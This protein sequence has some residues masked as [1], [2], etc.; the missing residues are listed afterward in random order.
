MLFVTPLLPPEGGERAEA[1]SNACFKELKQFFDTTSF[2]AIRVTSLEQAISM[3]NLKKDIICVT[4]THDCYLE[5]PEYDTLVVWLRYKVGLLH[6]RVDVPY[7]KGREAILPG[8]IGQRIYRTIRNEFTGVAELYGGPE[9]MTIM[10]VEGVYIKPPR[11]MLLPPGEYYITSSYPK[12][13]PRLDTLVIF[14]GRTTRK[15]ILL[16]P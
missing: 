11:I 8:E 1:F 5:G 10:L 13:Q 14:Q 16:L 15:R 4:D 7:P 2:R 9:G 12:F 3:S 6:S